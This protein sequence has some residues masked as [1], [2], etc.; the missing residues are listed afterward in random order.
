MLVPAAAL[1]PLPLS[2][3]PETAEWPLVVADRELGALQHG[4]L[5]VGPKAVAPGYIMIS[6]FPGGNS[7][8]NLVL[9]APPH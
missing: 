4:S 2:A 8:P 3:T 9:L 7:P 1:K 5:S 6:T